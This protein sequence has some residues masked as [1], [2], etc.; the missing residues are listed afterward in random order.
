[1]IPDL[2]GLPLQ[3]AEN[4]LASF[5]MAYEVILTRPP[6]VADDK[7]Q[8]RVVAQRRGNRGLVLIGAYCPQGLSDPLIR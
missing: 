5:E 7:G 3:E 6:K 4:R 1:M 2:L 8:I